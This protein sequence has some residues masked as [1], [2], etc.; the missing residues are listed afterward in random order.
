MQRA[1]EEMCC[2]G[3]VDYWYTRY[4]GRFTKQPPSKNQQEILFNLK[5]MAKEVLQEFRRRN[6]WGPGRKPR[7]L[8]FLRD[9][10]SDGQLEETH[11][12]AQSASAVVRGGHWAARRAASCSV[13]GGRLPVTRG[14]DLE[15]GLLLGKARCFRS[16]EWDRGHVARRS[17]LSRGPGTR[18]KLRGLPAAR[19]LLH[20]P[21]ASKAVS[22]A[23]VHE[24]PKQGEPHLKGNPRPGTVVD[25]PAVTRSEVV[26]FNLVAHKAIGQKAVKVPS[27]VCLYDEIFHHEESPYAVPTDPIQRMCYTLCHLYGYCENTVSLPAPVVY[28]HKVAERARLYYQHAVGSSDMGSVS[29]AGMEMEEEQFKLHKNIEHEMYW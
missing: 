8:I 5:G 9:G 3:S 21:R 26:H 22:T 7:N 28:S 25:D 12:A 2:A 13:R 23:Q 11:A 29:S 17:S 10:V 1:G 18:G 20:G 4:I 16:A 24:Y 15:C 27:Y 14:N 6:P 19:S